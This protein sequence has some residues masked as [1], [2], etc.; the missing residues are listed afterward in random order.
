MKMNITLMV[1]CIFIWASGLSI[2]QLESTKLRI[3]IF[4][5][6]C[7]AVAY[8][9]SAG[10][11]NEMD[12]IRT[13][14]TKAKEKGNTELVEELEQLGPTKQV[15]LHQQVFSN[16]SIKNILEKLREKFP[17]LAKDNEV[18]MILS[19]WEIPFADESIELIDVTDQLTVLFNPDEETKK[20]IENM[21]LM[22]P[23]PIEK[24]SIDPMK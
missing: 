20:V 9:R 1:A 15:L 3:G 4:D 7:I 5:S 18:K 23:M 24:I 14:H 2:S 10:F 11:M 8:G 21:K 13:A 6:R 17:A 22:E 16:G 12:S 19:K